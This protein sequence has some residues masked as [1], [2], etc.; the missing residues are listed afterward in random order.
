MKIGDTALADMGLDQSKAIE[1]R[2]APLGW[3]PL[4]G[5]GQ[6]TF[7]GRTVTCTFGENP[8]TVRLEQ[9]ATP[10][11]AGSDVKIGTKT[12]KN[13]VLA[14]DRTSHVVVYGGDDATREHA[15]AA[16]DALWDA[17]A[18]T[19]GGVKLAELTTKTLEKALETK[20]FDG[21]AWDSERLFA[22]RQA[23]VTVRKDDPTKLE[24]TVV[25]DSSGASLAVQV[26]MPSGS[27]PATEKRL[28]DVLLGR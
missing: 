6:A 7:K 3:R 15:K 12:Y 1:K 21:W 19:F 27:D 18:K 2:L 10:K 20:G 8:V 26:K 11:V 14:S 13:A 22:F 16:M 23:S 25:E 24:G 9:K 28:A 5:C 4:M 17:S